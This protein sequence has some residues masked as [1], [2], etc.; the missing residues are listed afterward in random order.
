[1]KKYLEIAKI[2]SQIR[3]INREI[4]ANTRGP[5]VISGQLYSPIDF[6]NSFRETEK[7]FVLR[8]ALNDLI[9]QRETLRNN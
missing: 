1:M 5:V 3:S 4:N 7:S 2:N 8:E 6:S 9:D